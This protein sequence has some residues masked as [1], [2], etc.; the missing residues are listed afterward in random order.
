MSGNDGNFVSQEDVFKRLEKDENEAKEYGFY[1]KNINQILSQ[2]QSECREVQEAWNNNDKESL[3]SE[4][5]DLLLASMSVAI[6]CG[7]DL[8]ETLLKSA[9]KFQD[10]FRTVLKLAKDDG[11]DNLQDQPFEVLINYWNRA[12]AQYK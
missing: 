1:W 9:D 12:K 11:Y 4:I 8:Q 5:G 10:R 7:L 2:V 3:K 6:F